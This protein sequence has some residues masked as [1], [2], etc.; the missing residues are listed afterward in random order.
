[1]VRAQS[2]IRTS[3]PPLAG[4][5]LTTLISG[6]LAESNVTFLQQ[7]LPVVEDDS[8]RMAWL[9]VAFTVRRSTLI[10]PV[11]DTATTLALTINRIESVAP[12]MV[13]EGTKKA[14][15]AVRVWSLSNTTSK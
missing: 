14:A 4:E 11:F 10:E 7:T 13:I 8:T 5:T 3:V 15:V 2:S 9:V 12:L 1:M 6:R